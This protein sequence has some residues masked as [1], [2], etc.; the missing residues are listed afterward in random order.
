MN[1]PERHRKLEGVLSERKR[2]HVYIHIVLKKKSC[3]YVEF[4]RNQNN[5]NVARD[6]SPYIYTGPVAKRL[7]IQEV[8]HLE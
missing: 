8:V 3:L 1:I 2:V 6:L 7:N 5:I 4:Q